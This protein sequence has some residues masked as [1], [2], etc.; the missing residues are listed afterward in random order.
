V[1]D[2][3]LAR[4]PD[5][6][7][8][9]MRLELSGGPPYGFQPTRGFGIDW[10]DDAGEIAFHFRVRPDEAAIV[11]NSHLGGTWN[12]EVRVPARLDLGETPLHLRFDVLV[13][14]FRVCVDGLERCEFPHRRAPARIRGVRSSGWFWRL[15]PRRRSWRAGRGRSRLGTAVGPEI[16]PAAGGVAG[17]PSWTVDWVRAEPNPSSATPLDS[18]RL[19]AVLDTWLEADIVEATVANCLRQGCERV[20]VVDNASPDATVERAI[21]AGAVLARVYSTERFDKVEKMRHMQEVVDEISAAEDAEHIWWLWLD[22]DEFYHGPRGLTLREFLA[23]LD[24]RFRIVG[25]RFLQHYPSGAPAYAEGRHPLEFQPLFIETPLPN[26]ELGHAR[27]SLQRWDRDGERI[28]SHDGFHSADCAEQLLEPAEPVI[29]HHFPFRD[30]QA[31][32]ARLEALHGADGGTSRIADVEDAG[33]HMRLRLRSLDGVYR[34]RWEKVLFYPPL[35]PGYV[36]E[37]RTWRYRG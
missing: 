15:Y 21:A 5:G 19:F 28:V 18:F 37:F 24:R 30:E 23:T 34:Q 7:R 25:G 11:L 35:T 12:E 20:Y 31:T 3:V 4:F 16:V 32:R 33:Y 10:V 9:P 6:I 29:F 17:L 13:D 14:R 27:H 22:A 26:C 36:P 8:P 2:I 1:P